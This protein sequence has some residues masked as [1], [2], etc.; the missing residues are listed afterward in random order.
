LGVGG[1]AVALAL[2]D[3]LSNFFAGFYVSV[4]GQIRVGDFIQLDSGQQGYITDIG[5]RSTTLRQ[6]GNNLVVI[7]NNKLAQ[8]IV[9]NYSLPEQ[10]LVASVKILI[11][12]KAK[13]AE[14]ERILQ[15]VTQEDIPGMLRQPAPAVLLSDFLENNQEFTISCS[16][17]SIEDQ[18]RVQHQLRLRAMKALADAGVSVRP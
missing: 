18:F 6:R 4:A 15:T 16:V 1:L 9:T 11:T 7:P 12:Y 10:R 5:W 8:S 13:T 2:Q 17:T 14:V 3:T